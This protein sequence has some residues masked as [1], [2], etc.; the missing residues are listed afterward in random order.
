MKEEWDNRY[1]NF[2]LPL[3][4]HVELGRDE[5]SIV[6][7]KMRRRFFEIRKAGLKVKT[8]TN[9]MTFKNIE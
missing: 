1:D 2:L 6:A 5:M 8:D 4:K 7:V 9:N 3:D